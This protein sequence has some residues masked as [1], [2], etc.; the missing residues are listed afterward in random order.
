[1]IIYIKDLEGKYILI[2]KLF[3]DVYQF[4]GDYLIGKCIN[5]IVHNDEK[6]NFYNLTVD[7][8]MAGKPS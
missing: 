7:K 8:V 6:I 5:E 2:N 3:S 1:M 4:S